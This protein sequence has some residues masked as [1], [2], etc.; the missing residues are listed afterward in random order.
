LTQKGIL[1]E[2][3][4]E[5]SIH[6]ININEILICPPEFLI[7]VS[8]KDMVKTHEIILGLTEII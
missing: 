5:I 7:L 8:S 2:I 4:N 6:N 3:A 1:A